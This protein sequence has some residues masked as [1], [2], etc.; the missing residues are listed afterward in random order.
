MTKTRRAPLQ[1]VPCRLERGV[2]KTEVSTK[3]NMYKDLVPVVL[4]M[5]D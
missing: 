3:H 5:I 1:T 4:K 2:T